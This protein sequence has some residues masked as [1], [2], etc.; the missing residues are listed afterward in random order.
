MNIEKLRINLS[1]KL[2]KGPVEVVFTKKNGER[3]VMKCTT[4]VALVPSD[5]VPNGGIEGIQQ[6]DS[7]KR[8]FDLDKNEW[9]SFR[10]DSIV[11]VAFEI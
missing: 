4:A 10:W 6:N 3:R 9:R 1:E 2:T 7:A 11:N 8:V 5:K